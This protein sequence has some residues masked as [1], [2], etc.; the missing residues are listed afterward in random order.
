MLKKIAAA[1]NPIEPATAILSFLS[2]QL[3]IGN[4]Y[5]KITGVIAVLY[6]IVY[7]GC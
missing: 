2:A 3:V 5:G 4:N 1:R 7:K 6:F